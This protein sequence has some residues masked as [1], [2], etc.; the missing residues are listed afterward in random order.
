MHSHSTQVSENDI[1]LFLVCH[2]SNNFITGVGRQSIPCGKPRLVRQSAVQDETAESLTTSPPRLNVRILPTIPSAPDS[3]V[4][5]DELDDPEDSNDVNDK[6]K[7]TT[8]IGS[9]LYAVLESG[10]PLTKLSSPKD[11]SK[12]P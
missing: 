6:D 7:D 3:S 5:L 4:Q 8:N 12:P 11:K 10:L 9:Q 2:Y 1:R